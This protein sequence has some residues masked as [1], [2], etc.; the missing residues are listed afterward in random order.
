MAIKI[1]II[2][3]QTDYDWEKSYRSLVRKAVNQIGKLCNVPASSEV[4][5]VIVDAQ[6][7]REFNSV[8]RGIDK[9][10]DVLSFA[11]NEIGDEEPAYESPEP[12]NMLGDILICMERAYSQAQEYGHTLERELA[13]LTVHGMLHLLGYEHENDNE[14]MLMRSLE[15]KAMEGLGLVR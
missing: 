1:A 6:A 14:K 8:Y 3:Q 10:T 4:N 2:N 12:D 15:E 5:V 11:I 9:E 13:F 7:I